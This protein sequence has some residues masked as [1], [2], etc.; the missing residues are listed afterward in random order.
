MKKLEL[1]KDAK[2]GS[3]WW[4]VRLWVAAIVCQG[5]AQAL[6]LWSDLVS[7]EVL[8]T[9]GAVLGTAGLLARFIKQEIDNGSNS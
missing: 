8:T 6:P 9:L 2:E 5:L 4:S 7:A 1:V 3:K